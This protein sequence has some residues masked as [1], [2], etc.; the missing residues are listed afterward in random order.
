MSGLYL[1]LGKRKY[2]IEFSERNAPMIVKDN[3]PIL[4]SR[5]KLTTK[6]R[7]ANSHLYN[8]ELRLSHPLLVQARAPAIQRRM[9]L[10]REKQRQTLHKQKEELMRQAQQLLDE[11][12]VVENQIKSLWWPL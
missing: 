4:L 3:K 10:W 8:N 1:H 6:D 2:Q 5:L 9:E 7:R 11:I 12:K